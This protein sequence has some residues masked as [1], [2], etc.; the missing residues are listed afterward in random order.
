MDKY[1]DVI[2]QFSKTFIDSFLS[3]S[4][5]TDTGKSLEK[6]IVKRDKKYSELLDNYIMIT[7]KRNSIKEW[8]KWI[9][10]WLVV[11]SCGVVIFL[12]YKTISK[13]LKSEDYS[14]IIQSIPVII[15]AF[16]SCVTSVIAIPL[17]ITKFLF[18]T[19]EDD[20]IAKIIQHTQD[21]DMTGITLLKERFMKKSNKNGIDFSSSDKD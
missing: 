8:H 4:S 20:N 21:H 15:T 16:V 3:F 5:D 10:F 12:V 17:T 2:K 11:V 13:I 9:F 19:N 6:E 14:V 1:T 7:K 18:N